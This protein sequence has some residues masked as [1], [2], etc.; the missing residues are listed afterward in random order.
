M[1]RPSDP[2]EPGPDRR[3][4]RPSDP[5]TWSPRFVGGEAPGEAHAGRRGASRRRRYLVLAVLLIAAAASLLL[6]V[7]RGEEVI[8]DALHGVWDAA[9]GAYAGRVLLLTRDS[10]GFGQGGKR[11]LYYRVRR[12][13]I[14]RDENWPTRYRIYYGAEGGAAELNVEYD[15]AA[16]SLRLG[17][18]RNVT[19][20][21]R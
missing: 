1:S 8:P 11:T 4:S 18:R 7:D 17:G 20:V 10:L 19:W 15:T 2:P 6:P 12:V 9:G 5:V 3:P 14:E 16:E 21:R 13:V